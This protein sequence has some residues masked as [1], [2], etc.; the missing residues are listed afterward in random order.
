[1]GVVGV[2]LAVEDVEDLRID[3]GGEEGAEVAL[4]VI[5]FGGVLAGVLEEGERCFAIAP[6][7]GPHPKALGN[8][9]GHGGIDGADFVVPVAEDDVLWDHREG[10]LCAVEA[11]LQEP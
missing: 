3:P 4:G 2:P 9:V 10:A 1:M 6:H 8:E 7:G 11:P 5:G